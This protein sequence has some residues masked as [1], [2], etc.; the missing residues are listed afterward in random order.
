[1]IRHGIEFPLA[2]APSNSN[3]TSGARSAAHA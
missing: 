1:L 2:N 3:T